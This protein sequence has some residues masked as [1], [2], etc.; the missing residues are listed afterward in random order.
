MLEV[1]Y[2]ILGAGSAGCVMANRLSASGK[3]KVLLVEA[4]FDIEPENEPADVRSLFPLSTYNE[5]YQWPGLEVHWRRQTSSPA[6][7]FQQGRVVGG[8]SAIMGMWAMRGH[9]A[10]YDGWADAGASGWDWDGVLPYFR[11]LESDRDFEGPLHG[12][13]GPIPIRRE[14]DRSAFAGAVAR[15]TADEGFEEIADMNADFRDGHCTLP[16]SRHEDA[17]ASAGNCYLDGTTRQRANLTILTQTEAAQVNFSGLR[18]TGATLVMRGGSKREVRARE[19]IVTCGAIQTPALLMRSGIGPGDQLRDAGIATVADLAG[20]GANLENH[21]IIYAVALL[22]NASDAASL[23]RPPASTILRWST[24]LP[25][26]APSDMAIYIRAF[27]SWH[28]LGR[29]MAMLAPVLMRPASKGRVSL[30][31]EQKALVEFNLLDDERDMERLVEGMKLAARLFEAA[32]LRAICGEPFVLENA[33]RL[34]SYNRYSAWNAF[35]SRLAASALDIWPAA[36]QFLLSRLANMKPLS[37]LIGDEEAMRAFITRS[38][39]GTFHVCGT[40]RMGPQDDAGAVVDTAG[41]VH[42]V[43]GLVVAD[44]SVMPTV[45]SGNTHLPTVMVAEKIADATLNRVQDLA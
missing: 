24:G 42:G 19:T 34:M 43:R 4:G 17:R 3:A 45:P 23:E 21:L 7:P 9:P 6:A 13:D 32:P 38:I 28:A 11:K 44:A 40:C 37:S 10:D 27:L 12:A 22:K 33:A 30:S 41:R 31:A 26:C 18:A 39:T 14:A 29:R 1:D 15:A 36:G 25:G 2:L 20:V 5:R 16:V 35:R 8:G